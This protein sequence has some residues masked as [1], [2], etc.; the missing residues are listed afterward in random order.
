MNEASSVE[1]HI[2]SLEQLR[3]KIEKLKDCDS[4]SLI[5]D[6]DECTSFAEKLLENMKW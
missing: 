5:E 6:I 4:D 3:E 2:E 1:Y